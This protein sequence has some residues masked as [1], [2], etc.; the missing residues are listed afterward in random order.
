MPSD[1]GGCTLQQHLWEETTLHLP[2][3]LSESP[4]PATSF[5]GLLSKRGGMINQPYRRV[6]WQ[7]VMNLKLHAL[8]QFGGYSRWVCS[9]FQ[10]PRSVLCPDVAESRNLMYTINAFFVVQRMHAHILHPSCWGRTV[11]HIGFTAFTNCAGPNPT[12]TLTGQEE[13]I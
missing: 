6:S 8:T 4:L 5:A 1:W 3:R 11:L 12:R 2:F 7:R 9:F 10:S 13:A